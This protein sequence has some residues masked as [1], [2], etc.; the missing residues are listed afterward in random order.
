MVFYGFLSEESSHDPIDYVP[1]PIGMIKR[2]NSAYQEFS[3][4][5]I[6]PFFFPKY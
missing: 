1:D 3:F 5:P 2:D 6:Q 4:L